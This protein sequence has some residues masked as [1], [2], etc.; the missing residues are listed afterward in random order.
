MKRIYC[1]I[2]FLLAL[3]LSAFARQEAATSRPNILIIFVDDLGYET[4]GAYGG[5]DFPTPQIDAMAKE[6][7]RFSRAYTSP[8]C[9]PSRVSLH[10]GLYTAD[11]HYDYVLPV[12]EGTRDTISFDKMPTFA[13]LFRDH[14][15]RTSVTGKWQLA[16]LAYHPNH[17]QQSGFDS[18]C[19]WQIWDGEN[20]VKTTRYWNPFLNR[21]GLVLDGRTLDA[22]VVLPDGEL[23]PAGTVMPDVRSDFGPDVLNAYVKG[24][25]REAAEADEPFLILH[26]MMLPHIPIVKTPDSDEPS[27]KGMIAYMDKLVGEL[28]EEVRSLGIQDNTYVFFIGDNGT[29]LYEPRRTT[30][31]EVNGAKR[32]LNDAGTHVPFIVWGPT[33]V[34]PGTVNDSL[35]DIT[36]V[37]PTLCALADIDIPEGRFL[38]GY[39]IAPQIEGEDTPSPRQWVHGGIRGNQSVYDGQWRYVSKKQSEELIDARG[40]PN[41]IVVENPTGEAAEAKERLKAVMQSIE[42]SRPKH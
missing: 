15:Y 38:R 1:L 16:T 17:P 21:D 4:V 22:D 28:L 14:G 18:W 20:D 42:A 12:H 35:V 3:G 5:L 36:D 29:E 39:S 10:S 13:M 31:G 9:T 24:Q 6:G 11:H 23:L 26:N 8:V 27:L 2:V 41:E 7:M 25:M 30:H 34:P 32:D 37:Y 40:T 19:L 33:H